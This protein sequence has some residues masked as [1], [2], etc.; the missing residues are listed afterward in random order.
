MGIIKDIC[1]EIVAEGI[2]YEEKLIEEYDLDPQRDE[3][4]ENI[5]N[6]EVHKYV[7][8]V[9]QNLRILK[10]D[11]VKYKTVWETPGEILQLEMIAFNIL[12]DRCFE[13]YDEIR[14]S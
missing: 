9:E 12:R 13:M 8:D 5:F 4:I 10:D 14:S 3:V 11:K 7:G 1:K 6:E 2:E